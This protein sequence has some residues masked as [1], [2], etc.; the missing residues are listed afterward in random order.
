MGADTV[1]FD[2]LK[3]VLVVKLRHH[4]DV[5]LATP[6][7][8][9]LKTRTPDAEIDALIYD[10]TR[11]ML[12][13]HPAIAQVHTIGR[14][15]RSLGVVSRLR[16]ELALWRRLRARHYDLIIHLTDAPRGAWLGRSL[17][18]TWAVA[19]A[20]PGRWWKESFSHQFPVLRDG[21]RHTVEMHLDALRRIGL[22]PGI[23]QRR[24]LIEP[25]AAA[26][27][28]VDALLA[29]NNL[30]PMGFIHL[31]PASRWRFKCWPAALNATLID[32]LVG[33]G[34]RVVLTGAPAED[35]R[36][37]IA[38]IL[39]RTQSRVVNLTGQLS[40][41]QLAALAARARIFVGVD[42]APMHIAAAV[43]TPV[44]ALFGPS[45]DREWGPWNVPHRVVSSSRHPCRP[46]GFDGC[47]G[48]KVSECLTS[49]PAAQ[50]LDALNDLVLETRR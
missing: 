35:E 2:R 38:D 24:L 1:D 27:E 46:C 6:V 45:G 26:H 7:F 5:L 32:A 22:Q 34:H 12:E 4:G 18:A 41:K 47:G 13:G 49:I 37:F 8:G 17:G 39:G 3:R 21:R 15:W 9:V 50:V 29:A 19:P 43:N 30:A 28:H 36:A 20:R 25:G 23:N 14:A 40:L 11:D 42:S 33:A 10:D 31:H 48:G 44:V 16:H